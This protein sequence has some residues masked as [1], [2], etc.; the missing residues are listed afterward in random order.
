MTA[1]TVVGGGIILLGLAAASHLLK[2]ALLIGVAGLTTYFGVVPSARQQVEERV[3][4]YVHQLQGLDRVS[5]S[6]YGEDSDDE[7]DDLDPAGIIP[8][9]YDDV[10]EVAM[11]EVQSAIWQSDA[12]EEIVSILGEA[13]RHPARRLLDVVRV[14][15]R[16]V[17]AD[18]SQAVDEDGWRTE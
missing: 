14:L 10:D 6:I 5:E 7:D 11:D 12:A 2:Y 3:K 1:V 9:D 15:L 8:G 18:A 16:D 17:A 4:E 13:D